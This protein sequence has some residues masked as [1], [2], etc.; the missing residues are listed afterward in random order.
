[1]KSAT[2]KAVAK[3]RNMF[4]IYINLLSISA[5]MDN[6]DQKL[7]ARLKHDGREAVSNLA[8]HLKVSRATI[9]TRIEKLREAGVIEG[10]T[11]QLG[12]NHPQN[13]IR[14]L[15]MI[16][17]EGN[18]TERVLKQLLKMAN[19]ECV[20]YTNGQWDFVAEISAHDIATLDQV[21]GDIRRLDGIAHSETNLLLSTQRY[22]G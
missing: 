9:R 6:L 11:V 2:Q 3:L 12:D 21:L 16:K 4:N 14:G 13:P 5:N 10:F 18:K 8:L 17:I 15:T 22:R 19:I 7:L 20:H 1:M